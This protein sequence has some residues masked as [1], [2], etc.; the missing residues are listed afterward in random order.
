M[1]T[2]C[3]FSLPHSSDVALPI[4]HTGI[5]MGVG[6]MALVVGPLIGGALTQYVSWRWCTSKLLPARYGS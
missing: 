4:V 1:P 5:M 3:L 6:Q 2:P